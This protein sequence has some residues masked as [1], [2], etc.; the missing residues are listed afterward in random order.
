M[1]KTSFC[2]VTQFMNTVEKWATMALNMSDKVYKKHKQSERKSFYIRRE[3]LWN[4]IAAFTW[5]EN[6]YV[7]RKRLNNYTGIII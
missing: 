4:E 1:Q 5:G 3:S 7:T 6:R 2:G